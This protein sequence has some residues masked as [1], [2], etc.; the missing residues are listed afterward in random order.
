MMMVMPGTKWD[1]DDSKLP[2]WEPEPFELPLEIERRRPPRD[3]A[4]SEREP[5]SHVIEFDLG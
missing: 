1:S 3:E 4:P 5:G 2:A